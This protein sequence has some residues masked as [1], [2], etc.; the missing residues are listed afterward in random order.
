MGVMSKLT[1]MK[2]TAVTAALLVAGASFGTAISSASSP[3]P[4]SSKWR[5]CDFSQ[6]KW[7]PAVGYARPVAYVG[8]AGDGSMVAK[9][10]IATALPNTRYDVRVIQAPR[11]S[12]G[13]A[14]GQPGVLTGS[15]QT[16]GVGAG[17]V[18]LQGPV[19]SGKTGAWVIV[20]RPAPSSQTPAEFYTS[21]F[22][23]T[24]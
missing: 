14:P 4:L 9:V 19:E 20:E 7:V 21:E 24:I 1:T 3:M 12:I 22:I 16:D 11:P 5:A 23:A 6:Q 13:C 18:T 15:V 8:P 2:V 17:S 10:D